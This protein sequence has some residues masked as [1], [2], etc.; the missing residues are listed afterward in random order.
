MIGRLKSVKSPTATRLARL[1]FDGEM[2]EGPEPGEPRAIIVCPPRLRRD[3]RD[4]SPQV[5]RTQAPQMEI[6]EFIAFALNGLTQIVRHVRIG[7][8]IQ[9]DRTSVAD[10]PVR[11]TRDDTSTRDTREGVHPEPAKG[12]G[13][14]QADDHAHRY[15]GVGNHVDHGGAHVVVT[16]G[17]PMRV[18]VFLEDDRIV[19]A[20]RAAHAR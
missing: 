8:H 13:E 17:C 1:H 7:V 15:S 10:Q 9:Q 4:N 14:Q 19:P 3:D 20:D 5:S 18:L 2:G 12:P 11:P 16:F 6:G